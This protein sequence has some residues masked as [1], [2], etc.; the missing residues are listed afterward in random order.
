[1]PSTAALMTVDAKPEPVTI[2]AART[3]IVVVAKLA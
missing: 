1:M 2:D 3:A